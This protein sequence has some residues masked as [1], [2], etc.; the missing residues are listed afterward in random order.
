MQIPICR[1]S[2]K[3]NVRDILE[4]ELVTLRQKARKY[5]AKRIKY[6]K[7]G[8]QCASARWDRA[9]RGEVCSERDV[10]KRLKYAEKCKKYKAKFQEVQA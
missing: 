8:V 3:A 6:A 5:S 7:K 4:A 1:V 10:Q 2:K 9:R